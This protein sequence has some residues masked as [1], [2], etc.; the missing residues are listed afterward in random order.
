MNASKQVGF[1]NVGRENPMLRKSINITI[2]LLLSLLSTG[3]ICDFTTEELDFGTKKFLYF[4]N[5]GEVDIKILFWF[6]GDSE[7]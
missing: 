4:H 3:C 1:I 7:R 5:G 6:R 2:C